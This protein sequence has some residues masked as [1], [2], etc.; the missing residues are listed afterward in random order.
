MSMHRRFGIAAA[1][2]LATASLA[3][4]QSTQTAP[5]SPADTGGTD[6]RAAQT[7]S[8][9]E[10]GSGAPAPS[11]AAADEAFAKK[12]ALAGM[13]EVEAGKVALEKSQDAEV[14]KFAR[15]MVDDHTKAG[16]TLRATAAKQGVDVPTAL[17]VKSRKAVD[18][19]ASLSATKFDAAYKAEMV[20]DHKKVVALFQAE[21]K[22]GPSELG[23]F[24]SETV[25]TLEEH[26]RMAQDLTVGVPP[27]QVARR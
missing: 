16:E 4:A 25:P 12:A 22:S 11:A 5:P 13:K 2:A 1:A 15:H 6:A 9:G 8:P 18:K 17:D 3:F 19:L 26:L 27:K 24:A 21:A 10:K 20:K 14:K 7:R 23:R